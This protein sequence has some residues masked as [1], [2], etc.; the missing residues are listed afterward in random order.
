[1]YVIQQKINS[2]VNPPVPTTTSTTT[3]PLFN[4]FVKAKETV[5]SFPDL[6]VAVQYRPVPGSGGFIPINV[7]VGNPISYSL[8]AL[9]IPSGS[10]VIIG[11]DRFGVGSADIQFGIGQNG[12]YTGYCGV[13]NRYTTI[14]TG[15]T[16]IYLNVNAVA[17]NYVNCP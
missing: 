5:F 10:E 14:W 9:N 13:T 12:P 17:N 8:V 15:S 1:M 16:D 11:I 7:N 3:A 2:Y 6:I 4:V